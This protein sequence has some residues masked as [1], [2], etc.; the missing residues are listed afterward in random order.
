MKRLF[1]LLAVA[2][3]SLLACR[4]ETRVE[5]APHEECRDV[6]V[7]RRRD[8]EVCHSKCN[9][10]GCRTKCREHERLARERRCWIED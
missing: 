6:V 7:R 9:D 1:V 8:V 3:P 5:A 4:A 10:E 2:A